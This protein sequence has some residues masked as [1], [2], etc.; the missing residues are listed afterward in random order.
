VDLMIDEMKLFEN[1]TGVYQC[2]NEE[3]FVHKN[4][5]LEF[6]EYIGKDKVNLLGIDGMNIIKG[7][8]HPDLTVIEDYSGLETHEVYKKA[9]DFLKNNMEKIEYFNFVK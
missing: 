5:A 1:F 8:I 3:Y 4:S 6:L 2:I 9:N 7:H